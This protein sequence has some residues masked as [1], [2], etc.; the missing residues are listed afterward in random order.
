MTSF[1]VGATLIAAGCSKGDAKARTETATPVVQVGAE[2]IA[3]VAMDRIE[4]GPPV[5][6]SLSAEREAAI[7]AEVPGSVVE[8][9]AE[10]GQRVAKDALLARIDDSAIRESFISARS[11]VT[12]AQLSAEIATRELSR[13]ERL[14]Q[15]GAIA[16]RDLE[17]VRRGS[18]AAQAQL[19][20]A[21]SRLAMAEKQ[22]AATQVR[23]PFSGIVGDRQVSAGDVVA[24][25]APLFTVVDPS[26]MR[27]EASLPAEALSDVRI[28]ATVRFAVTGYA[29][30]TFTGRVSRISP[31]ADPV[32]R[33]VR[34]VVS[35]PST[36]QLVSGLFAE[37]RVA[38]ESKNAPSVPLNAVDRRGLEPFVLR[39]KGGKVE[40][41]VV[42]LGTIDDVAERIEIAGGVAVGDTL[43]LGT[44]Q[45][46]S[47]GTA[48]AVSAPSDR[49]PRQE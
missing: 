3:I 12:T 1:V 48:V 27:L 8:I 22:L 10:Q 39:I 14:Q 16:D 37:G 19:A 40:K 45:G 17:S 36:G 9:I 29:D 23:A 11:G 2:N 35:I 44:A 7:R 13:A 24:P 5:S 47:P 18:T 15:A 42:Q 32:T 21:K 43:L 49:A 4:S 6:G 31:S 25:G 26:S 33:Q 34:I 20:D 41:V 28:G 30:R 38:T 46:I